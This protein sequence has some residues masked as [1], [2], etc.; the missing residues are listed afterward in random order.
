MKR[1]LAL[2][3]P[4]FATLAVGTLRAATPPAVDPAALDSLK[5]MSATLAGAKAFTVLTTAT[6]EVPAVT[7]QAL[8]FTS[9]GQIAL[10]RPDRLRALLAGDAPPFDFYYDGSSVSVFA[11]ATGVYSTSKAPPTIDAMLAGLHAETGIR[12]ATMPLLTSDPYA[13]LSRGMFSAVVVGPSKVDGKVC[14]HL[15]FRSAGVNWEIW[16]DPDARALPRRLAVTFTDS[17][18]SPRRTLVEFSHWNLHP[19]FLGDRAF[20]FPKPDGAKEIPFN[21]VLK[22][23]GREN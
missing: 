12:F 7:G 3:L 10:R 2:L 13:A 23:A 1:H 6:F 11:P 21:S 20:V 14:Q 15:A 16:L 4:L 17:P 5:R 9:E 8:T 22:S 19:W 18:G